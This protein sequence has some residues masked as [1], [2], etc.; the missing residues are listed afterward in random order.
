M[1]RLRGV[2][3]TL[4]LLLVCAHL[5]AQVIE[6]ESNGLHY[7]TATRNG[8][9]IM[10]AQLPSTVREYAVMQVSV[11]NG[12]DR[13]WVIRP[14]DFRFERADGVVLQAVPARTVVNQM[15]EK[16]T[17]NDVVRL[18]S[19]Y[20]ASLY[21]FG[22]IQSTN[23]YEQRRQAAQAE[24]GSIKLKAAAAASAIAFVE[25]KLAPGQSTDGAVFYPTNGKPLGPGR[26]IVRAAD[27]L[28]VFDAA[29]APAAGKLLR[30]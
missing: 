25:T 17:R 26:L 21:G 24:L 23:G 4:C 28:F 1:D 13:T 6:F 9:T 16:A 2:T 15:I 5:N 10:F 27:S 8:L 20:E 11:S 14:E 7:L 19:T 18:V 22:R 12:S 30:R 29:D 3:A